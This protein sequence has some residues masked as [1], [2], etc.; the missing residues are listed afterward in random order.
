MVIDSVESVLTVGMNR[1]LVLFRIYCIFNRFPQIGTISFSKWS[2]IVKQ[3]D[4]GTVLLGVF[5]FGVWSNAASTFC[6]CVMQCGKCLK[7]KGNLVLFAKS[8]QNYRSS[9]LFLARLVKWVLNAHC[10]HHFSNAIFVSM[11]IKCSRVFSCHIECKVC[12][13]A[14]FNIIR[15]Q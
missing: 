6:H 8:H 14:S 13:R 5:F 10:K 15:S 2:E 3:V 9:I 7:V 12:W 1:L 11:I 4:L